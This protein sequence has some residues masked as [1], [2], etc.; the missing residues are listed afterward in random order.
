VPPICP[1]R[2]GVNLHAPRPKFCEL[3]WESRG[4]VPELGILYKNGGPVTL[5]VKGVVAATRDRIEPPCDVV[6]VETMVAQTGDDGLGG[7]KSPV[8]TTVVGIEE[9]LE[10]VTTFVSII[11][12]DTI[13]PS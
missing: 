2:G 5:G 8:V 6:V 4:L 12:C 7:G 9:F 3:E 1:C 10:G 11:V 13:W